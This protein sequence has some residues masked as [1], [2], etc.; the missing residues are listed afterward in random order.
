MSTV[1]TKVVWNRDSLGE[2]TKAALSSRIDTYVSAGK[3]DGNKLTIDESPSTYSIERTWTD[4]S[5]A[6]DWLSFV[7]TYSPVSAG[8]KS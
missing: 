4:S 6:T 8:F 5:A 3:T 1:T 2:D 7:S